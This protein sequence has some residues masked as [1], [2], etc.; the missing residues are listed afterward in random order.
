MRQLA[1]LETILQQLVTEHERLLKQLDAHQAAMKKLDLKA[2]EES[3]SLE[4]ATRLRIASLEARRRT[5]VNQLAAALKMAGAPTITRIAQAVPQAAPRLLALRDQLRGIVGQVS[6][7][8]HIA[9]RIAGAV[10]GHV[11][12]MVRLLAGAVEQGGVYT[13]QGTPK[14]TGRIGAMEAVG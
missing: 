4:E 5:L 7:R 13:K 14:F 11:N 2:I 10:L 1:D 9:S 6:T 12:T 8:A 3:S